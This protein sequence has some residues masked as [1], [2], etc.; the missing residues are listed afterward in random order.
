VF[1][2]SGFAG[3]AWVG[4]YAA[5][6]LGRLTLRAEW[7]DV[8]RK[9]SGFSRGL[10]IGRI[11]M[12]DG[13]SDRLVHSAS[14]S[15]VSR[16]SLVS[17]TAKLAGGAALT[18]IGGTQLAQV[19]AAQEEIILEATYSSVGAA[20]GT[21]VAHGYISMALADHAGGAVTSSAAAVA[22]APSGGGSGGG[23][24]SGPG[25]SSGAGP[26][27]GGSSG[28]DSG[29]G[30]AGPGDSSGAGPG[31]SI[32]TGGGGTGGSTGAG[33]GDSSGAGPGGGGGG[34]GSGSGS[35]AGT[36]GGGGAGTGGGGGQG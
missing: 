6:G 29:G 24:G 32:G 27:G 36:G 22:A 17:W 33:P 8:L 10:V 21:A 12:R 26:G 9:R 2:S 16:R 18:A 34:G 35:G 7:K 31:A 1:A 19:A 15:K 13:P 5:R 30:G 28:G 14:V 11:T 20:P 23:S 3:G 25:D 4:I